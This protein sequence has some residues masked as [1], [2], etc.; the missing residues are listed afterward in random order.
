MDRACLVLAT[1]LGAALHGM[2]QKMEPPAPTNG[3]GY[4]PKLPQLPKIWELAVNAFERG[5]LIAKI[6][7][8]VL[9]TSF[10]KAKRQEMAKFAAVV[11][12]F[13][14]QTYWDCA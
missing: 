3:D 9:I 12:E 2:D 7:D 8:A 13:E 1:V 14:R 10:A 11:G 6:F 4:D 5:D